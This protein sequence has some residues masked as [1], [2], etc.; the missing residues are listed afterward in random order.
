MYGLRNPKDIRPGVDV[1]GQVEAVGKSVTQ[2]KPADV[3]GLC[4]SHPQASGVQCW[5][6]HQGSFAEYVCA[7]DSTLVLKLVAALRL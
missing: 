6:H 2:F 5:V 7:H 3:F 4:I 1:A